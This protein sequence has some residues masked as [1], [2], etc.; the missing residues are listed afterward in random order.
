MGDAPDL[1]LFGISFRTASEAVREGLAFSPSQAAA[2]L[3]QATSELPGVEAVVLSTCNRTEFYLSGPHP[4]L[5][6]RWH[7]L[8]RRTRPDAPALDDACSRYQLQ[9][10]PALRH[11][12][13][14]A[15]GLDSALLGDGQIV[16]QVR[17]ALSLSQEAGALGPV[18]SPTVAAALRLARR[19]RAETDIG[20]GAP[21]IGGAVAEALEARRLGAEETVL[22]LGTGQAARAVTRA[23]VKAGRT[24]LK[25]A[26][27][28]AEAATQVAL[29]CG[30]T[31]VGWDGR[32]DAMRSVAAVVAA[33]AATEPVLMTLPPG[34]AVRVVVDAGFP[35]Q[36]A[37]RTGC[38]E[39]VSLLELTQQ[40]DAAAALRR[41]AVPAVEA[42]V[43]AAV[44]EWQRARSRAP[45]EGLIK[46]LHAEVAQVSKDTA[47][48]LTRGGDLSTADV[49]RVV[50]QQVRRL[51]H[52]HVARLR[53]LEPLG[54]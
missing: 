51:L 5:V 26:G 48:A 52:S 6:D 54:A 15:C 38:A 18:L 28:N 36:V 45:L 39:V 19:A 42:M 20:L 8:L 33:T 16:G 27:R 25:V 11:L 9:G 30:G 2:L 50:S 37:L 22:V 43:E 23:L 24:R 49:E 35:R 34:S 29:E 47:E 13:R 7:A 3:S 14:V 1:H 41:A 31:A 40:A 32:H 12:F 21:G 46:A 4:E 53:A 17:R 10:A 44:E